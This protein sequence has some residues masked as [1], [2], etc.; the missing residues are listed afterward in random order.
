MSGGVQK[1]ESA[2][3]NHAFSQAYEG[4]R[5]QVNRRGGKERSYKFPL[6]RA[7]LR[8]GAVKR[9]ENV[10]RYIREVRDALHHLPPAFRGEPYAILAQLQ[11]PDTQGPRTPDTRHS[12]ET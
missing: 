6:D 12:M 4:L 11:A 2:D 1:A 8:D 7:S 10:L 3:Q 5:T 9:Y